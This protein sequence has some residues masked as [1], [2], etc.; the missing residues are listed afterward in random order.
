MKARKLTLLSLLMLGSV[1]L[2]S[3]YVDLGF[4]KFGT[5]PSQNGGNN[6]NVQVYDAEKDSK[7]IEAYYSNFSSTK[8]GTNFLA[9]LR[10]YNLS[11]RTSTVGYNAMG[12]SAS[13]KFK[14]TDYDP[15]TVRYNSEG[16]PYG[17]KIVSF[18]TGKTLTG[19]FTREHVWPASRLPGGRDNNIVDD[20]IYMPRP[21]S[22]DDNGSRENYVYATGTASSSGWDPVTEFGTNGTYGGT[23]I[24]GECAR[25]IF[26]CM[27]V[28]SRLILSNATGNS[29][30]N[31]GKL[32]DLVEWSCDNPVTDREK[33]RNVGGQYLQG[34][35][36][37]FVD[38][39]EYVCKIW[40]SSSSRTKSACQRAGYNY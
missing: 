34:N 2:S 10:N 37:S 18:Y 5:P 8:T 39:P 30:N 9:D 20:D 27:L 35:R 33:R 40:G 19:T 12:S 6:N 36:N 7:A 26:Y 13:G 14:Y 15:S 11:K 3:C 22:S 1:T 21:E 24:R 32:D 17:T 28:D 31:M 4:I 25:I 16:V 38:H 23:A 29:G